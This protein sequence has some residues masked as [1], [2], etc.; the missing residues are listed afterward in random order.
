M[1][2]PLHIL[3]LGMEQDFEIEEV[4]E[5]PFVSGCCV[6]WSGEG[7]SMSLL[8]RENLKVTLCSLKS[9]VE[10]CPVI[11]WDQNCTAEIS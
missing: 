5:M 10:P 2:L 4:L 11:L 7:E 1:Y 8:C 9:R 3:D 6:Y